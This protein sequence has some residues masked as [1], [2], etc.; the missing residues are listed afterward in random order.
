MH[1]TDS[2]ARFLLAALATWRITHLLAEEDGPGDVVV[3]AR[4]RIGAGWLGG[5]MDC[6]NCLSIWVAA[7]LSVGLLR[8]RGPDPLAWLALSGTACLLEQ[9]TRS[10]TLDPHTEAEIQQR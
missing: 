5:M 2:Q 9:A 6:F 4:A 7:P 1:S 8:R 3:R 10:R